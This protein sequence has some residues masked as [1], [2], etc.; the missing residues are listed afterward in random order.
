MTDQLTL[1]AGD[2][3][4]SHSAQPGSEEARKMTATSGQKCSALL[5]S[6]SPLGSLVRTLLDSPLWGS[7]TVSL[8]W[9][10]DSLLAMRELTYMREYTYEKRLCFSTVSV[11]NLNKLDLKSRR[12]LFRL[13]PS[14]PRTEETGYGLLPTMT[15]ADSNGHAQGPKNMTLPYAARLL[16]TPT[17]SEGTGAQPN[18]GRTGGKS[19]RESVMWPTP[20]A[21]E[22]AAG[23]PNGKMQKMLGNHPEVRSQGSGTLNPQWVEWLMGYPEGWTNLEHSETP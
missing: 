11:R 10:A 7:Q 2:S 9:R 3:R 18:T 5:K 13:V 15:C 6:T 23:T 14:M 4:A 17:A 22:D 12:L 1:F 8:K 21:N 16:P 20:S 19:L